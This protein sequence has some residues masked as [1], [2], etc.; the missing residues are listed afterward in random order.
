MDNGR[1]LL[2]VQVKSTDAASSSNRAR[3]TLGR[4][5]RS[6]RAYTK[7]EVD[8]F[9]VA[10]QAWFIVP[11]EDVDGLVALRVPLAGHVEGTVCER[12]DEAWGLLEWNV[13]KDGVA[14]A[15]GKRNVRR[16]PWLE[17]EGRPRLFRS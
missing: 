10:D 6:N 2:R 12:F 16:E 14:A 3:V 15:A 11:R 13:D 9:G 4:G 1:D 5:C 8:F 7:K 17:C